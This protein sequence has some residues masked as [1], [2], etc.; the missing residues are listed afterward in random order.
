[1]KP[2][3]DETL[4]QQELSEE[5]QE[6]FGLYIVDYV[7]INQA[8]AILSAEYQERLGCRKNFLYFIPENQVNHSITYTCRKY[9]RF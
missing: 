3:L 5:E 1:M 8:E 2:K 4:S 6:T 9:F 7:R